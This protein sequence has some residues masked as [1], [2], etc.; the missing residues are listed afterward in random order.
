MSR[1]V[2]AP[3]IPQ[4]P[5][6]ALSGN[7]A[8]PCRE[9]PTPAGEGRPAASPVGRAVFPLPADVIAPRDMTTDELAAYIRPRLPR[10]EA[11]MK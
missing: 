6:G 8:M 1:P 3:S 2:H 10:R 4:Y 7:P 11:A 9:N 5:D